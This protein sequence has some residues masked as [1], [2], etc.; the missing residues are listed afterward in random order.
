MFCGPP[1]P[2]IQNNK[3]PPQSSA[4]SS[5][6]LVYPSQGFP[7]QRLQLSQPYSS[8]VSRPRFPPTTPH[9]PRAPRPPMCGPQERINSRLRAHD[10][11]PPQHLSRLQ[12]PRDRSPVPSSCGSPTKP[13]TRTLHLMSR[14]DT[15]TSLLHNAVC[16]LR[17]NIYT[18]YGTVCSLHPAS[19]A[20]FP[21]QLTN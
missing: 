12:P 9:C 4:S 13:T 21:P 1:R 8:V 10:P 16:L 18:P 15:P 20:S 5:V 2:Q 3:N 14:F 11:P 7:P 17:G 19:D 6:L